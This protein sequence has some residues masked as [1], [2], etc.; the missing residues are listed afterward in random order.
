MRSVFWCSALASCLFAIG[1]SKSSVSPET[2][3]IDVKHGL[4]LDAK[5]INTTPKNISIEDLSAIRPPDGTE[6]LEK[7]QHNRI[8]PFE[9]TVWTVAATVKSVQLRKDGDY[10]MELEGK[11]GGRSVVEVPDPAKCKGSPLES[12]I[13]SARAAIEKKY[14]PTTGKKEVND[15]AQVEGVGFFGWRG[16][17][18]GGGRLMPGTGITFEPAAAPGPGP[19]PGKDA[20]P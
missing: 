19:G 11:S 17:P 2:S 20:Q 12:Q 14:H 3:R 7:Y 8:S 18:S 4:D 10:Y 9:K 16:R 15:Q 1:C 6:D 5:A 13:T